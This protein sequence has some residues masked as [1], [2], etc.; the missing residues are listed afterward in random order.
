MYPLE[1]LV[2]TYL[3]YLQG[4]QSTAAAALFDTNAREISYTFVCIISCSCIQVSVVCFSLLKLS[5]QVCF[6]NT[7]LSRTQNV[8]SE[9][10]HACMLESFYVCKTYTLILFLRVVIGFHLNSKIIF[11]NCSQPN[12]SQKS[13][14]M[15]YFILRVSYS[16]LVLPN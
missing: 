6:N 4:P 9:L 11:H 15:F 1:K 8:S 3:N 5:C 14:I 12:V 2:M 10:F 16:R 13:H 7:V